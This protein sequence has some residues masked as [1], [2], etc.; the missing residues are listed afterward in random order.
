MGKSFKWFLIG[1]ALGTALGAG[2]FYYIEHHLWPKYVTPAV[3]ETKEK[4]KETK[5]SIDDT[6]DKYISSRNK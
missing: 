1:T 2:G 6:V 5:D 3:K 4:V